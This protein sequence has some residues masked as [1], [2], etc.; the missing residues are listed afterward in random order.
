MSV[1]SSMATAISGL[2]ANGQGLAI[3]S[4]NIVNANTTGF[5]SS[6]GEFQSILAQ[7]LLSSTGGQMGRGVS[8]AGV[9][10]I[11]SQGAITKTERGTDVA[12]NG[13]GFFVLRGENR[14]L[15]FTRDGSFGF[16]KEGWLTTLTGQRV[17]AYVADA[18]GKISGKTG[19]IRIPY[20]TIAA[21]PTNRLEL[22]FNLDAR[23]PLGGTFDPAKPDQTSQYASAF[24]VYDSIGSSHSVN[25]FFNKVAESTWSWS[26]MADG[27]EMVGG[28]QG[29]PT[30][31][32]EGTLTFD[33]EGKLQS[34][35]QSLVNTS[36]TNGAIADQKFQFDFGDPIDQ[37]GTG[38]KG[39][40]QYGSK[41]AMFRNIQDGYS[42]GMLTDTSIDSDG[43]ITGIYSNGVNKALGQLA[44]A[45]FEATERL[46]RLGENQFR[47]ST[48]SGTPVLGRADTNGL[49]TLL[50][51]SLENS[52]VDLAKEFVEMIRH[53]RGFQASAKSITTANDMLDEI[54]NIKRA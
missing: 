41:S 22:N 34:S 25:L 42:A 30:A 5:K 26:A 17:Q 51:R 53:Q 7:D 19:D 32:A 28:V 21:R 15:T 18:N 16:D 11:F 52:N 6:R 9:T 13:A 23:L 39:T 54:I 44:L 43:V 24:Q 10:A 47:E 12:V 45:R 48:Q 36:F 40:T 1:L 49:G 31:I 3:D 35:E 50:N 33:P 38:M 8:M 27:A 20:K 2:E 4:D 29:E 14:G 37:A 46:S